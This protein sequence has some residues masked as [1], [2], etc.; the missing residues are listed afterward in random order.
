MSRKLI[1]SRMRRS[2]F[3][4]IGLIL[5]LIIMAFVYILPI[6]LKHD[7][8]ATSLTERFLPPDWF[9]NG[10]SGHPFG[11]D[12]LGRDVLSRLVVGGNYS[13]YLGF[14]VVILV[15]IVGCVLGTVSGYFGGWADTIIMRFCEAMM[16]LPTMILAIAMIAVLGQSTRNLIIIMVIGGWVQL[17]KLTRNNVRIVKSQEFVSASKALGAK[18]SHI[19]F[20]QIFPNV[21]TQIIVI[22]SQRVA[23]VIM[24]EAG[25]SYLGLGIPLPAPT[26]GNMISEGRIYLMSQSWLVL[27]PGMCLMLTVLAFNFLGDG[28]RDVLDTR[29]K[30]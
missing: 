16:A 13:F 19:M 6:F 22:T 17:C 1:L 28:L 29:R 14:I 8:I 5:F 12:Y 10:F 7:P 9:A 20:R 11:T 18:G 3:F 4:T 27:I 30:A 2:I 21:T 24:M 25:L 15:T 26:W 23:G